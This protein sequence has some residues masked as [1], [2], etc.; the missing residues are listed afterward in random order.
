MHNGR[1]NAEKIPENKNK[2]NVNNVFINHAEKSAHRK[3]ENIK[4]K[5][6]FPKLKKL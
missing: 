5:K 1:S 3:Q 6:G 2:S 4:V